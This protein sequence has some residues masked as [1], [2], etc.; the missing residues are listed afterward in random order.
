[1]YLMFLA[2]GFEETEALVTLDLLR[3]AGIEAVT[4]GIG[5][6]VID[7][8]HGIR[9]Y[10]DIREADICLENCDGIILPG[11]MPGTENLYASKAVCDAVDFCAENNKLICAIC[12][13]PII[14]G[15]KGLLMGERAVC[16]PGFE[17]ELSGAV[18]ENVPCVKSG[19][20]ITAKGA[21]CVFEFSSEIISHIKGK[22]IADEVIAVIQH[23][24]F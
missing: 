13:A 2:N 15:R 19:N 8:T 18:I 22:E 7:G 10:S 12:A 4:V 11:G 1:M 14:L 24:V 17:D 6:D 16:F 3:R 23:K 20:F 21:G 9:V 5:N